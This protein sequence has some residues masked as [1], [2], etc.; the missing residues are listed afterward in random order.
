MG[1]RRGPSETIAEER[2]AVGAAMVLGGKGRSERMSQVTAAIDIIMDVNV[3][4]LVTYGFILRCPVGVDLGR[5][6]LN[7]DKHARRYRNWV[8]VCKALHLS[9]VGIMLHE[10]AS[11]NV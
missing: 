11:A 3:G 6:M 2:S 10:P 7:Y 9:V 5:I 1:P 8:W 4:V